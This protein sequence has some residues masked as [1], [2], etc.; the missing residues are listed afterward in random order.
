MYHSIEALCSNS[1]LRLLELLFDPRELLLDEDDLAELLLD[2]LEEDLAELRLDDLEDDRAELRLDDRDEDLALL[3][4]ED[5]EDERAL[6]PL[7]DLDEDRALLRLDLDED[8]ALL[9]LE[10]RV[11]LVRVF[12][13]VDRVVRVDRLELAFEFPLRVVPRVVCRSLVRVDR[14]DVRPLLPRVTVRVRVVPRVLRVV[15]RF[16]S[17]PDRVLA[18]S[19]FVVAEDPLETPPRFD[20]TVFNVDRLPLRPVR[21]VDRPRLLPRRMP[22]G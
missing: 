20:R 11:L 10:D 7:E 16:L 1:Y 5:L 3:L 12:P 2:D 9:P 6:L 4:L 22:R 13:F 21:P 17:T 18:R 8:R 14:V 15:V 19:L